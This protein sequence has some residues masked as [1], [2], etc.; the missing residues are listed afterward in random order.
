MAEA[1]N[2][3]RVLSN[4]PDGQYVSPYSRATVLVGLGEKQQAL[5]EL[6]Q[7]FTDRS[8]LIAMLKV[9]PVFDSLRGKPRFEALLRRMNF[10]DA[11]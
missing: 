5:D 2:V 10:P 4:W 1:R 11:G 3:A 7:A 8:W 9:D 6:E